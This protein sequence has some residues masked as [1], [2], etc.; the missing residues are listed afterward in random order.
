MAETDVQQLPDRRPW[1]HAINLK[2]GARKNRNLKG[3]ICPLSR[4]EQE[5]LDKFI[6]RNLKAGFIQPSKSPIASLFFFIP[7][8]DRSRRPTQD[9]RC[10][11]AETIKN[12]WPL[13]L[14][15][16]VLNKVKTAKYFTKLD[17]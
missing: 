14:I 12:S 2:T 11:N 3:K 6:N 5:E 1:N 9:Y 7:K 16:D 13:P 15:S 10:I 4:V 8:K 17:I